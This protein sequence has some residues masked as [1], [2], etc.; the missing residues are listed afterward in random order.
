MDAVRR[1]GQKKRHR[2]AQFQGWMPSNKP[3]QQA[4]HNKLENDPMNFRLPLGVVDRASQSLKVRRD[5]WEFGIVAKNILFWAWA[6]GPLGN[7]VWISSK[8]PKA[9]E[10]AANVDRKQQSHTQ[11]SDPP[12]IVQFHLRLQSTCRKPRGYMSMEK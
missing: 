10:Y 3:D 8:N 7:V 2:D 4:K 12:A 1:S 11:S 5:C 9:K 6:I